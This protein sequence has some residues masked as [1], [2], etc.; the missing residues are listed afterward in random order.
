M[1]IHRAGI[2]TKCAYNAA[3]EKSCEVEK[4]RRISSIAVIVCAYAGVYI[5]REWPW[6]VIPITLINGGGLLF[7]AYYFHK[8]TREQKNLATVLIFLGFLLNGLHNLD[9]PF[10]RPVIWFA[11]IGFGLGAVFALIFAIGLIM[12]SGEELKHLLEERTRELIQAQGKLLQ[13]E[14][15]AAIGQ[16]ASAVAHELINPLTGIRASC[17]R[18]REKIE[19]K[20]VEFKDTIRDIDDEANYVSKIIGDILEFSRVVKPVFELFQ[21]NEIVEKTLSSLKQKGLLE[22]IRVNT[23]LEPSIPQIYADK[24]RIIQVLTNLMT[25]AAQAMPDGGTLTI[26]TEGLDGQVVIKVTDTGKGIEEKELKKIFN[27]FTPLN[28]GVWALA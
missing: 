18:I 9:Y 2:F 6:S 10:L 11:P 19:G 17:Y 22:K 12:R 16:M 4:Y 1:G 13:S 8:V 21:I 27:P 24:I 23:S 14:K 3:S 28:L 15:M 26:S 5:I 20:S 7:C 25:N